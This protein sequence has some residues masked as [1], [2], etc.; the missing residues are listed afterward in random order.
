MCPG[1]IVFSWILFGT[2]H[3]SWINEFQ[4]AAE[5]RRNGYIPQKDDLT[6]LTKEKT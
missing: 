4:K 1:V 5:W 6:K 2:V 3:V